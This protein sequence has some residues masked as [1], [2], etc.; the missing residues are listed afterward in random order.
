MDQLKILLK[1]RFL[2]DIHLAIRFI[3][4]VSI[5]PRTN[6]EDLCSRYYDT[7]ESV[8]PVGLREMYN[9]QFSR[10][11]FESPKNHGLAGTNRWNEVVDSLRT[12]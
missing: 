1:S 9:L 8:M 11:S 6:R 7:A 2:V 3:K 5:I 10:M 4:S 12:G